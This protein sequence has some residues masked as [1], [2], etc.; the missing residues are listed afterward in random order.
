[1]I[2]GFQANKRMLELNVETGALARP[3]H[4]GAHV[5]GEPVRMGGQSILPQR[6]SQTPKRPMDSRGRQAVLLADGSSLCISTNGPEHQCGHLLNTPYIRCL[7][8]RLRT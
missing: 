2:N 3:A 4:S 6:G 5:P 1:M 7:T 8:A